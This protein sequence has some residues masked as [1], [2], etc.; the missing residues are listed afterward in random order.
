MSELTTRIFDLTKSLTGTYYCTGCAGR[1]C[2]G[3]ESLEGV[4]SADC[5]LEA[6][7]LAVTYDHGAI[8]HRDLE[9]AVERLALEAADRVGHAAY[10]I[11]GLD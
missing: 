3:I 8:S 5:D 4:A 7:T 1:V 9:R 10:R 11:T 6:G 2:D